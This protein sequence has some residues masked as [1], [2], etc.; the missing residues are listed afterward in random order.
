MAHNPAKRFD[1]KERGYLREGY[2][3]DFVIARRGEEY[4]LDNAE[5][6]SKCGWTPFAGRKYSWYVER[7]YSNGVCVYS[8]DGGIV[9]GSHSKEIEFDR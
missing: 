4:E 1:V 3:A 8:R 7:T 2:Y 6:L 9:N 5:V